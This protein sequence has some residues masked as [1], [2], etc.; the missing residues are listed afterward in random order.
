MPGD[1]AHDRKHGYGHL[2]Y[3]S[4]NYYEGHFCDDQKEGHGTMHWKNRNERYTGEWKDNKPNG[5]GVHVWFHGDPQQIKN[6]NHHAVF[7]MNNRYLSCIQV[8][9]ACCTSA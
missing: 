4:G 6:E 8:G 7:I 2:R 3:P 5:I 1:W 9:D